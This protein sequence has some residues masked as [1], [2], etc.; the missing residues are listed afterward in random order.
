MYV[1][2]SFGQSGQWAWARGS[3]N[4]GK[5]KTEMWF[6]FVSKQRNNLVHLWWLPLL[7]IYHDLNTH[8][9]ILAAKYIRSWFSFNSKKKRKNKIKKVQS[10]WNFTFNYVCAAANNNRP[11]AHSIR[12]RTGFFQWLIF[13]TRLCRSLWLAMAVRQPHLD[14]DDVG[15]FCRSLDGN[16]RCCCCA[17]GMYDAVTPSADDAKWFG[18]CD[19]QAIGSG[20]VN[21]YF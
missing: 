21:G 4:G 8:T 6:C 12:I 17:Y 1:C 18:P 15:L 20:G 5:S 19:S 10:D 14:L 9:H 2:F 7:L 16:E 3:E 13:T 11:G